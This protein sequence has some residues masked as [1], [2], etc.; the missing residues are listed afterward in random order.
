FVA[1]LF[2]TALSVIFLGESVG[3]RRWLA[4]GIGFIGV[5]FVMRPGSDSFQY[6]AIL[7]LIAAAASS[8]SQIMTRK[9][10]FATRASV[11]AFYVHF[12]LLVAAVVAWL[13]FGDG[14][15]ARTGNASLDFLFGPWVAIGAGDAA[16]LLGIGM[17]S[18]IGTYLIG[19]GYRH[20]EAA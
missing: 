8:S 4:V 13:L 9:I 1:P 3:W 19:Q 16:I 15:F 7:P 17:I 12:V 20:C 10:G 11:L 6:A 18:A 14:R 5:L 2:T